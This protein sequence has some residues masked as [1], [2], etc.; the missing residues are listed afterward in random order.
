VGLAT[1]LKFFGTTDWYKAGAANLLTKQNKDGSWDGQFVKANANCSTAYALLFLARG[2]NPVVFNKLQYAGNWNARGRDNANI[3][4]WMGKRFEKPINWQV[5]NLQVNGEEWLDAPI[6]LITGNSDPKFTSEDVGKLRAF[7]NAGG[8]IFSTADEGS[9]GFTEAMRKY[10]AEVG[11]NRYEMRQLPKEHVLFSK[12]LGVEVGNPPAMLGMSNGVREV[13]IHSTVDMGASWQMRRYS[14]GDHFQTAAALYFYASG[15]GSLR[16]KLQPL[17]V[18]SGNEKISRRVTVARIGYSG[19]DD[20]EPGAWARFAQLARGFGTEVRVVR[21]GCGELDPAKHKL[22]HL[23]GTGRFV[24]QEEDVKALRKYLDGGG[25]LF[26]D[27]AGG[28]TAFDESMKV[29]MKALYPEVEAKELGVNHPIFTGAMKDGKAVGEVEFRQYGNLF[30]QK[31]VVTPSMVGIS[32]EGKTRVIYSKW[33]VC[34]GFLGTNTWGIVGYGAETSE[35]IGRNLVLFAERP[36][37]VPAAEY[38][39]EKAGR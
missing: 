5:V 30:L 2:R 39:V 25:M 10:A 8:M 32:V 27:A 28:S 36:V 34:S 16:S 26:A 38:V 20:P 37:G 11:G 1:G 29:L 35:V 4:R 12:E 31:R 7:V 18:R 22:A 15:K 14:V 13:W 24:L 19:N 3:T 33:D 6:L 9:K 21:V 23:T 17:V